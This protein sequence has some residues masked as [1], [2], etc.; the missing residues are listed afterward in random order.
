LWLEIDK[1]IIISARSVVTTFKTYFKQIV[2][3]QNF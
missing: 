3:T 2:L 1:V